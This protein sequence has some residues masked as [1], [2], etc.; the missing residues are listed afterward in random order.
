MTK[1]FLL[2]LTVCAVLFAFTHSSKAADNMSYDE[3]QKAVSAQEVILVDV[4]TN[5]EYVQGH[6]PGAVLLPYDAV[7]KLAAEVLPDKGARIVV[8]CR[9][10]RRSAIAADALRA[11]GYAD[12]RD[13]GGINRW[14]GALEK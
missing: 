1:Y 14:K 13:F 4:R 3:L 10:G 12:V 7:D 8:Y 6:I 5:D 9:S 2:A 11:L